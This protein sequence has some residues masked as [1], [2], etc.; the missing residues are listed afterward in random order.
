[1]KGHVIGRMRKVNKFMITDERER[2]SGH[3]GSHSIRSP[4]EASIWIIWELSEQLNV[5][6]WWVYCELKFIT[7][8]SSGKLNASLILFVAPLVLDT[9][10]P[11]KK[12]KNKIKSKRKSFKFMVLNSLHFLAWS[13]LRFSK[14]VICPIT[15][16]ASSSRSNEYNYLWEVTP[17]IFF[18]FATYP[19]SL[20]F[21]QGQQNFI[22]LRI[23]FMWVLNIRSR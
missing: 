18:F 19:F 9:F 23:N 5:T 13:L 6:L 21:P 11:Q 14:S 20:F 2:E 17:N 7:G 4:C 12:S 3:I 22:S 8:A 10:T 15:P 16:A 1:M